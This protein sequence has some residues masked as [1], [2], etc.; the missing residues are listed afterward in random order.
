MAWYCAVPPVDMTVARVGRGNGI[1]W[2]RSRTSRNQYHAGMDF[3]AAAGSP[4]VAVA[5]GRVVQVGLD[6]N[7]PARDGLNGYG[8]CAVV[9]ANYSLPAPSEPLPGQ[10]SP[11]RRGLPNPFYMLYAHLAQPPAVSVGQRVSVGTLI[12]Y[13][14]N[15]SNGRF[16]GPNCLAEPSSCGMGAHLHFE[17]RVRPFPG[18]SYDRDS[19]D[20]NL[21][22]ASLG[23]DHVN[24]RPDAGR[25][26][27]GTL[28]IRAG[29]PSDCGT[30]RSSELG[31]LSETKTKEFVDPQSKKGI[32]SSKG[33]TNPPPPIDVDP[34]DYE[35]ISQQQT[36]YSP[37]VLVGGTVTTLLAV[38]ALSK[39]WRRG[40]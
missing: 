8:N 7:R 23:I 16:S 11:P 2:N 35:E 29:G 6:S 4:V 30:S 33:V 19:V 34:P 17:V 10:S 37:V 22:F 1:G 14:G 38:L 24:S 5:P 31:W 25:R 39:R 40:S 20:P 15:T 3:M 12:G 27:G 18:G 32:Y 21:L 26:S 28:L 9:E 36:G 13:V